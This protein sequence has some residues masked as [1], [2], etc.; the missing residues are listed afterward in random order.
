MIIIKI[1]GGL[2]NQLF[3]YAFGK[4]LQQRRNIQVKIDTSSFKQKSGITP[5][6]F[7]L[8][9]F[10]ISLE[11]A[12]CDDF[13]KIR[14]PYP[15]DKTIKENIYRIIF[16]IQESFRTNST[17]K[18]IVDHRLNFNK[19][20]FN[21]S[22]N[23]YV[24]GV[25]TNEKYFKD[26]SNIL[27]NEFTPKFT[28]SNETQNLLSQI[29]TKNSVSVHIRRGDYLKYAHKFKI[30]SDQYYKD[31]IKLMNE[32]E[33]GSRFFVFSDDI[34][35]VKSKY[36]DIFGRDTV[37]VSRLNITDYEEIW[38]M[39]RCKHNIIANSTFSWWGAWLNNNSQ[40]IIVAPDQYRNDDKDT[41]DLMPLRW[42]RVKID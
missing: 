13:K 11:I 42:I 8:D 32:K 34:D 15:A 36:A 16:K 5:R 19:S 28:F 26:I 35:Y 25:W 21:I 4:A 17:R 38:L 12:T 14:V 6:Q 7:L 18:I 10:N 37:Y 2:G 24:S 23:S 39:S 30:L 9:R 40:K 1:S 31:A 3:Q 22:D 29:N 41:S 33:I 20:M 27:K